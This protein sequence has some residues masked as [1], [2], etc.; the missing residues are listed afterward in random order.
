[1][2]KMVIFLIS[3]FFLL[4][5]M[6]LAVANDNITQ[7]NSWY[8]KAGSV[9]GNGSSDYPFNSLKS[10]LNIANDNDTIIV[11][12]GYYNGPN[13]NGIEISKNNVNIVGDK[14]TVFTGLNYESFFKVSGNNVSIRG[15]TFTGGDGGIVVNKETSL[16]I[17]DSKFIDNTGLN[18]VCIDNHG[19][20]TVIS[21]YFAN[22][23]AI[24]DAGCIYTLENVHTTI[25]NSTFEFNNAGRNC[26]TLKINNSY[27]DV[28]NSIF[29]NNTAL[30]DDNFGGAIYQWTGTT[31]IYNS[32][33]I[34]NTASSCGGAVY[35]NGKNNYGVFK[36]YGCEYLNNT[37]PEGGAIYIE[38]TNGQINYCGFVN[39]TNTIYYENL[40]QIMDLNDNWWGNN[41]PNFND[42][43]NGKIAIENYT[44]VKLDVN[45]QNKINTLIAINLTWSTLTSKKNPIFASN[46]G[47]ITGNI[48]KTNTLGKYVIT[49]IVDNEV[50]NTTIDVV[51]NAFLSLNNLDMYRDGSKLIVNLS[52]ES[53]KPI[54]NA[55]I[56]FN[57]NGKIYN[58]TTNDDG[59]AFLT[60]NLAA[61]Q[62]LVNVSCAGDSKYNPI[63]DIG[64]INVKSTILAN[65]TSLFYLDGTKFVGK[66]LNTTGAVLTNY[67]VKF[68]INGVF[69]NRI[70]DLNGLAKLT[71][72][73]RP[74]NYT[75]TTIVDE[76]AIGNNIE[77]LPTL[78]TKNLDMKYLDGSSFTAQTLNNLGMPLTNQN[79]TFNINGVFYQ[80]NY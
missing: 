27:V 64:K 36:C 33:F 10:V 23:N 30:G 28:F 74:G 26:G 12:G 41:N 72:N 55:T 80:K 22:N 63:E 77:V 19:N 61:N 79:I 60:I 62:Y 78:I 68:N 45:S 16:N 24:R 21:S 38:S 34:N 50:L 6:P 1:M 53:K 57:I 15:F 52:D 66:F 11:S 70:T 65:N 71:I 9:D 44:T 7:E 17:I 47:N 46:G 2:N 76:L 73:L 67:D 49:T 13:N 42:L 43:I 32:S 51:Q 29:I 37:S 59:L 35:T 8:V 56:F 4:L 3:L 48:F 14:N 20:L 25:I 5:I 75:I 39:N 18:G 54:A 31:R 40:R 58:R 69:Y